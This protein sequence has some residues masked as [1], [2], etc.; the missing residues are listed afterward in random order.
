MR[1]ATARVSCEAL[2]VPRRVLCVA[3]E[4][5]LRVLG[6]ALSNTL[7]S[8]NNLA[9]VLQVQGELSEAAR[10]SRDTLE[11]LLRVLSAGGLLRR[12]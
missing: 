4:V 10:T 11:V 8:A 6:A 9:S 7:A 5:P 12:V 2:E 3:L 1:M